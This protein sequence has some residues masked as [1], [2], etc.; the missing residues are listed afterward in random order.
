[1]NKTLSNI[2]GVDTSSLRKEFS[3]RQ[4]SASTFNKLATGA[5]E[6]YFPSQI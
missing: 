5:F 1:M 4:I 6:P 3:D 2:L